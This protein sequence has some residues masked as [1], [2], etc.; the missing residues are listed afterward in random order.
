MI[1]TLFL[2]TL[3]YERLKKKGM[4]LEIVEACSGID[5]LDVGSERDKDLRK[6]SP[7]QVFASSKRA[8]PISILALLAPFLAWRRA[9]E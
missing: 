3:D 5:V 2:G 6:P 1:R 4:N 9:E 7:G 8:R